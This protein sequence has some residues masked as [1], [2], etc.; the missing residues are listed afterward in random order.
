MSQRAIYKSFL[1][2][3]FMKY[4]RQ[5]YETILYFQ[6]NQGLCLPVCLHLWFLCMSL[7]AA[8][9]ICICG[10]SYSFCLYSHGLRTSTVFMWQSD[11]KSI[12]IFE[13]KPASLM[14]SE[15]TPSC[16][17]VACTFLTPEL[18]SFDSF[19]IRSI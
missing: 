17:M 9:L 16:E 3:C 8:G 6:Y 7:F 4:I 15:C 10:V 18:F 12:M 14:K 11:L 2:S 19:W 1:C 5:Q 13:L